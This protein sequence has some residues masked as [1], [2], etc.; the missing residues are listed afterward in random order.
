[1]RPHRQKALVGATF[2][3]AAL[4][5]MAGCTDGSAAGGADWEPTQDVTITV[6]FPAGGGTD[7]AARALAEGLESVREDL[8]V[9]VVN[10]DGGS[11][12]VGY[13][14][15]SQQARNPHELTFIE[16]GF[17]VVPETTEVPYAEDDFAMVGGV[18]LYTSVI[19][20]PPGTFSDLSDLVDQAA[21]DTLTV[22]FPNATG[23]QAISAELIED[24]IGHEFEHVVYQNGGEIAAGVASGD[25]DFGLTALEHAQ[26]FIDDGRVEALAVLSDERIENDTFADVPTAT[27]AGVDVAFS[28]FRGVVAGGELTDGQLQYWVDALADYRDSEAYDESLDLTM[29]QE[30]D[31]AGD[32]FQGYL[33]EFRSTVTPVLGNLG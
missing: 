15:A 8:N 27:E 29:T 26:G 18:S 5:V 1:M 11:G 2:S 3:A 33:D 12:T 32:E 30:L 6:A 4:L 24:S 16:P 25:L 9:V 28:G 19:I 23:P 13:T 21:S 10:R 17:V 31:V 7:A 20:A 14:Y 22:G